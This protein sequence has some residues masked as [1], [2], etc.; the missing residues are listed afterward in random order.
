MILHIPGYLLFFYGF[1]CAM[2]VCLPFSTVLY[3]TSYDCGSVTQQPSQQR[4][5]NTTYPEGYSKFRLV[6]FGQEIFSVRTFFQKSPNCKVNLKYDK[7]RPNR[8]FFDPHRSLRMDDLWSRWVKHR[9]KNLR[10]S[11]SLYENQRIEL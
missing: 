9:L 4:I 3:K 11:T 7:K 10:V 5:N 2:R 1:Y 8:R 6:F